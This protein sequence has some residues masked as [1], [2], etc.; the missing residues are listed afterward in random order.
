MDLRKLQKKKKTNALSWD[1]RNAHTR[2]IRDA[3][4][5][6]DREIREASLSNQTQSVSSLG[7]SSSMFSSVSSLIHM[8]TSKYNQEQVYKNRLDNAKLHYQQHVE[9]AH[10]T[11]N[12]AVESA[13]R[14][15]EDE[16]RRLDRQS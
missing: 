8:G 12:D 7:Y 9:R 15:Y 2:S 11:L 5:E 1:I 6:H 3:Q 14:D 10:Q 13:N 4:V 16:L